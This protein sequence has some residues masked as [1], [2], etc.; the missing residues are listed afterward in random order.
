[1]SKPII[2]SDLG[3]ASICGDAAIYFKPKDAK[4]RQ[5]KLVDDTQLKALIVNG[6]KRLKNSI[7]LERAK[8]YLNI[9][10]SIIHSRM[11]LNFD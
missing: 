1:M 4:L 6:H 11:A 5:I 10:L 7:T 8:L 3:F 2:T 9:S